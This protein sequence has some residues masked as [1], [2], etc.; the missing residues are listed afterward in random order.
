MSGLDPVCSRGERLGRA[1]ESLG[2]S[3]WPPACPLSRMQLLGDEGM[4]VMYQRRGLR[5]ARRGVEGAPED[6]ISP[7]H[8][9]LMGVCRDADHDHRAPAVATIGAGGSIADEELVKVRLISDE[10]F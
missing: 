7:G 5:H 8:R 10:P 2:G 1:G 4:R 3:A 9:S 6:V